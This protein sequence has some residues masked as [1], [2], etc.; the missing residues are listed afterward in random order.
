MKIEG[1]LIVSVLDDDIQNKRTLEI[2]FTD[3]YKQLTTEQ[4]TADMKKYI[5]QLFQNAEALPEK[6]S[7]RQGLLLI[8]QICEELLP[9]IQQQELDLDETITMEL[10]AQTVSPEVSVSLAD[11]K[12]N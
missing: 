7:N 3:Q 11:F 9:F 8:M 10:A 2:D 12:M 5:Q 4:Q 6:D 1:P